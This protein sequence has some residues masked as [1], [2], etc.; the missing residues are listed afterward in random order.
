MRRAS[1]IYNPKSGSRRHGRILDAILATFRQGGFDIE[2]VPTAGPGEATAL[3]RTLAAS[4]RDRTLFAL[5]GDGTVREVA[6]GLL[7]SPVALGILPGGTVNL[8][9]LALGLPRDPV[10]AAAALC[11]LPPR[12]LDVGLA[13]RSPFLMMVS[14]GLDARI[15]AALDDDFKWRFGRVAVI[16]QGVREWW[17]Y[18]YPQLELTADGERLEATFAVVSNIQYYGGDIRISPGARP[19]DRQLE[20]VTFRGSGRAAT[21]GFVL[22]VLR[23]RH[24][25]RSDVA[26]RRVSE[27]V[28]P[29]PAGTAVQVDGDLCHDAPPVRVRL[30]PEPLLV[31]APS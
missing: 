6:A 26:I 14:A 18:S 12:P 1:L 2:P 22:E 13:G 21:L 11:R 20:L 25:R 15:L 9:A 24:I 19:D 10:D 28:F 4:S 30:A 29:V 8:M 16:L 23:T 31:L 7:G 5:G 17:R 27:V 3:A